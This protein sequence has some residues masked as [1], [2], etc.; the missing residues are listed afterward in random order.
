[1]KTPI[2][3]F[4]I[5]GYAGATYFCN[6][7]EELAWIQDQV[8]NGRNMV[9]HSWR[10]MGK[11]ALI[12]HYFNTFQSKDNLFI[13]ADLLSATS[14]NEG[15]HLIIQAVIN[16]LG[17]LERGIGSTLKKLL[18]QIGAT[19]SFDNVTGMPKI[20]LALQDTEQPE[21]TLEQV[22]AFLSSQNKNVLFAIDEFQQIV[23][24]GEKNTEALLR[25]W[26]QSHPDL[27]FLFSG[28]H[29]NLMI[30][31][32]SEANRPFYRCASIFQLNKID[33]QDYRNFIHEKFNKAKKEIPNE[34]IDEIL[35]WSRYQTY[36]I[37]L[38]CNKI[39]GSNQS[40]DMNLVYSILN[41]IIEQELPVF[42]N[43]QKLLTSTQWNVLTAIAKDEPVRNPLSQDFLQRHRLGAASSVRTALEALVKKEMVIYWNDTYRVHDTLLCRWLQQT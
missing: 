36:Y 34:I 13:Y 24:F 23:H 31:M 18:G 3:P 38:L 33:E 41:D 6:R 32:F 4:V 25:G 37:Q 19:I 26:I 27:R 20:K 2:N 1:M 12:Q 42:Y 39:Y 16:K 30:S 21:H 22:G 40:P 9:L 17:G 7:Q 28:S 15:L 10:R 11:T 5:S 29:R 43:Y 35:S 8:L 14:Q